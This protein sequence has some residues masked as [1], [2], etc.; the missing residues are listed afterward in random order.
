MVSSWL[1]S[2]TG[3][4]VIFHLTCP[5]ARAVTDKPRGFALRLKPADGTVVLMGHFG[6]LEAARGR[7][8][9]GSYRVIVA[10]SRL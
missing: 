2:A 7:T 8:E 9:G 4:K 10:V 5:A 3:Q 1:C 6:E